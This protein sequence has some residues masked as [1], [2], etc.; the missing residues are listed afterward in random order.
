MK[1]AL[2]AALV[3]ALV[4]FSGAANAQGND[5]FQIA[6]ELGTVLGSEAACGLSY[7]QAAIEAFIDDRIAADDMS[8][9]STLNTMTGGTEFEIAEMSPSSKTAHCRQI[10]RIAESYGFVE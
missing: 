5:S 7:D 9:P 3:A 4:A 1:N 10:R 6:L 2:S 8:F